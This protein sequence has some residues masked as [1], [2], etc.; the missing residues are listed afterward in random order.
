MSDR[1]T[2]RVST[3]QYTAAR[4]AEFIDMLRSSRG[5]RNLLSVVDG[6]KYVNLA[7]IG[8]GHTTCFVARLWGTVGKIFSPTSV[9]QILTSIQPIIDS[10]PITV[11]KLHAC[12]GINPFF[13]LLRRS[14]GSPQQHLVFCAAYPTPIFLDLKMCMWMSWSTRINGRHSYLSACGIGNYPCLWSVFIFGYCSP[15]ASDLS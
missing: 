4:C 2:S 12:P 5:M 3:F 8:S 10:Q 6:T 9:H 15:I 13:S 7:E 14:T 11:K 1:L